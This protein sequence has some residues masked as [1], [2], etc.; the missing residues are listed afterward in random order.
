MKRND[1]ENFSKSYLMTF[2][3]IKKV[4]EKDADAA[5]L[6]DYFAETDISI[7]FAV[8]DD[9]DKD[10]FIGV[11]ISYPLRIQLTEE[12]KYDITH[13]D[14]SRCAIRIY[15]RYNPINLN[16][17]TI[18]SSLVTEGKFPTFIASCSETISQYFQTIN[19][20]TFFDFKVRKNKVLLNKNL[21]KY[22]QKRICSY[23]DKTVELLEK[24]D[25]D[26]LFEIYK[27]SELEMDRLEALAFVIKK[28]EKQFEY[29]E[30]T[31]EFKNTLDSEL[32]KNSNKII[33]S[34]KRV[35]I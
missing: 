11:K 25:E 6:G 5:G 17:D 4:E 2:P 1:R 10:A 28:A 29:I 26:S 8:P 34:N 35:K 13:D 16:S 7:Y 21:M 12:N 20:Q 18:Y 9:E 33:N 30:L 22:V 27:E 32:N 23:L 14:L 24:G 31:S 3:E 15:K 19:E